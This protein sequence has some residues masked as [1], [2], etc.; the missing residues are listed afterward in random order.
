[1]SGICSHLSQ[2]IEK[3]RHGGSP[4]NLRTLSR[5]TGANERPII[6]VCHI[7]GGLVCEDVRSLLRF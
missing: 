5:L 1:M 2:R 4:R 3:R 7:L 6:F